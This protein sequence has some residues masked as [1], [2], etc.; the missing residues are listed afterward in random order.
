MSTHDA[1][2]GA[3]GEM[4]SYLAFKGE[5]WGCMMQLFFYN[6]SILMG[7]LSVLFNMTCFGVPIDVVNE[8]KMNPRWYYYRPSSCVP[9][10]SSFSA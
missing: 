4:M 2:H 1:T 7:V 3:Q 9:A 6:T 5:D 8:V 10:L